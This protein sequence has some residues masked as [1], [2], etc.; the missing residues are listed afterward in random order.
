MDIILIWLI[1]FSTFKH[2]FGFDFLGQPSLLAPAQSPGAPH[3]SAIT[4]LYTPTS[5]TLATG[6]VSM[7][8]VSPSV[9]YTVSSPSS[10]S[11]HILPKHTTT[12]SVT[13]VTSD[14]Q[15]NVPSNSERQ[16]HQDRQHPDGIYPQSS[17]RQPE[18]YSFSQTEKSFQIPSKSS[19]SSAPPSGSSVPL[20]PG[21]P[22]PLSHSGMSL[23]EE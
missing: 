17:D 14:R 6:V 23:H 22:A 20:Q 8:T 13:S 10:L 1:K 5:V 19:S 3:A 21:S 12:T 15:G 2:Y 9:V 18:K 7:G 11:P 16:S 4:A